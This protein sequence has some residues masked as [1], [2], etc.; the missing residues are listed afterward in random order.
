[1]EEG[2]RSWWRGEKRQGKILEQHVVGVLIGHF[3]EYHGEDIAV[4]CAG[5]FHLHHLAGVG[6]R[7]AALFNFGVS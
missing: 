2:G 6:S 4:D 1:M 5:V 3:I 7:N